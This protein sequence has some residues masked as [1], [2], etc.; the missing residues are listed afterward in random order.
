MA[1]G[2]GGV[3][4]VAPHHDV[5]IGNA[6]DTLWTSNS[7]ELYQLRVIERGWTPH[8]D[9]QRIAAALTAAL[10]RLDRRLRP[11]VRQVLADAIGRAPLPLRH[12]GTDGGAS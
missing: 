7:A 10:P 12:P 1:A 3:A 6:R 2:E 9:G 8:D 4:T 11:G 5:T